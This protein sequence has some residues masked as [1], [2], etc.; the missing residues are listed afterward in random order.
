MKRIENKHSSGLKQI[1]KIETDSA[2]TLPASIVQ[3][4]RLVSG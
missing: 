3:L 2:K 1:K 4:R